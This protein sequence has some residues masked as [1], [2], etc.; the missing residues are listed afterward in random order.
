VSEPNRLP[1]RSPLEILKET[2][3]WREM[4]HDFVPLAEGLELR[5]ADAE[6][7][8]NGV[9]SFVDGKVPFVVNNDGRLSADA[10]AVLFANCLEQPPGEDGSSVLELGG[11]TGLF[12]RYFLDEFQ[13]LCLGAGRDFYH[14]LTY[15]VT[16]RSPATVE[17]WSANGVFAKHPDRVRACVTDAMEP[18]SAIDRPLRAVFCNY[19]LDTLPGSVLRRSATGWD[20]LCVRTWMDKDTERLSQYTALSLNEIRQCASAGDLAALLSLLPL[21]EGEREFQPLLSGGLCELDLDSFEPGQVFAFNHG[22]VRCL[23]TVI[24]NLE[25]SGFVLANDYGATRPEDSARYAGCQWFGPTATMGLDF[26]LLENTLLRRY[27]D[28]QSLRPEGDDDLSIHSRLI[29]RAAPPECRRAFLE[30]F[31]GDASQRSLAL[32]E[33]ARAQALSGDTIEALS[34][35]QAA[36][37]DNP[38]NWLLIGEA[39]V[40]A[41]EQL[42]DA[43]RAIELAQAALELNPW[44]SPWL[45]NVLGESFADAG[46]HADAHDCHLRAELIHPQDPA[47]QSFLAGSWLRRGDPARSLYAIARGLT[48]DSAGMHRHLLLQRQQEAIGSLALRWAR[49][50]ESF[51]RRQGAALP[52]F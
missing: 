21:L 26:A 13:A 16:D 24:A 33:Q 39:A 36:L 23:E 25:P 11:G 34:S 8:V 27:P 2:P 12:A 19:I 30:R 10:A 45:W 47:T 31:S 1:I 9:A 51:A 40:F 20:R 29:H 43:S 48:G 38:R 15:V 4:I 42:R 35:F 46:R 18:A 22:A 44:Y 7:L 6:W 14:R 52:P 50:R 28:V 3:A 17:F 49:E 41:R 32:T 5:L 37:E